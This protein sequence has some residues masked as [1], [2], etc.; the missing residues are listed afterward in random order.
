MRASGH[1]RLG[2]G[3]GFTD[4]SVELKESQW[5]DASQS[6]FEKQGRPLTDHFHEVIPRAVG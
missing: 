3:G 4:S 5:P 1:W 6:L 2:G